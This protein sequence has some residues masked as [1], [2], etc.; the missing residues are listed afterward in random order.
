MYNEITFSLEEYVRKMNSDV[1]DRNEW[2]GL[3]A[4]EYLINVIIPI[5]G[6]YYTTAGISYTEV[7]IKTLNDFI[8]RVNHGEWPESV[9]TCSCPRCTYLRTMDESNEEFQLFLDELKD[10][11]ELIN[12]ATEYE[13]VKHNTGANYLLQV[14]NLIVQQMKAETSLEQILGSI[15]PQILNQG[16]SDSESND[17]S[18]GISMN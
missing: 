15:V 16:K 5:L 4:A 10:T 11:V 3:T 9:Q 13:E 2:D 1:L 6:S 8:H 17:E 7:M 12:N 18:F 14:I